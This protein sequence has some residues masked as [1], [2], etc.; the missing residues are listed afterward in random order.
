MAASLSLDEKLSILM[1][2]AADDHDGAGLPPRLRHA[3]DV[4]ALRP[5]NLRA[6]RAGGGRRTLLR[7]LM[8]NAC[9]FN[10]HY[11][12]M[13]RDREMP[14]T[15]LKP[16]ELVRIFL[17][18]RAR[19]WCDGLFI[20]TGIPGRPTAVIDELITVLE[21]LRDRHSFTGY[22]HV[23]MPPGGDGAQIERLTALA[24][25][26]SIN[27]ET[28][29]GA[30]LSRIAPEKDLATTLVSLERVRR[31]VNGAREAERAGRPRDPRRPGGTA[32]MTTQFIVGAT[33]DDD[34]AI[35]DR[36]RALYAGGGVHHAHFSAF[37]PIRDT[38]MDGVRAAPA[39]REHRLYQAD[40]LMRQYGFAATEVVFAGDGNLPLA[41]DPKA[42]W[43]LAHPER[44]PVDVR[45]ASA[46]VLMRVPGIGP[47]SA[48]RIVAERRQTAL[49]D[50]GDLRRIGV[51]TARAAGFLTI[52]GRRLSSVRWAEQLP[53]WSAESDVGARTRVYEVSPGTFR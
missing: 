10:C 35:L 18:A 24:S 40:Y 6:V 22:I 50:L 26:V 41:H 13:R 49:R 20:T 1:G 52:G 42:A 2:L 39:L 5:L 43:A 45:T 9:S 31:E 16:H 12:P 11:C 33:A 34:R 3:G 48:R 7:V 47:A 14:R 36:V 4:G 21:L 17:G 53:L 23:K 8:T 19:G 38:P 37:R 51:V 28:P 44:F 27:L 29:C 46:E 15:L 32:G 25:R 30:T